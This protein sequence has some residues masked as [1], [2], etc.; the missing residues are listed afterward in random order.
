MSETA[1]RLVHLGDG[2]HDD[3][4]PVVAPGDRAR[5]AGELLEPG[6]TIGPTDDAKAYI[7]AWTTAE[8]AAASGSMIYQRLGLL[9]RYTAVME[10]SYDPD[11]SLPPWNYAIGTTNAPRRTISPNVTAPPTI[12]EGKLA[13]F[14][15]SILWLS[16]VDVVDVVPGFDNW[17][18]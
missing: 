14:N 17:T 7:T 4:L 9:Q 1:F 3:Y 15:E 8:L 5:N 12:T 11:T 6:A 2:R 18:P 10:L 13:N 16:S